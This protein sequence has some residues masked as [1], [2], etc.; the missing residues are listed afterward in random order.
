MQGLSDIFRRFA[1]RECKNVSPLYYD[2]ALNISA[3]RDLLQLASHCQQR[4]PIPN[5][6]LASIHFL[7][8]KSTKE[9]LADFYPSIRKNNA[10]AIPIKLVKDFCLK[11]R[12]EIIG[13]LETRMVQTNAINRT[14]YIMPI[15]S[16]EFRNKGALTVIDIGAS[17]GLNLNFEHYEYHLDNRK[18]YG[19]SSVKIKSRFLEGQLPEFDEI[20]PV[21]RKIGIDQNPLDL[22]LEDNALW[23]KAL[24]WPDQLER[25]ERMKAAIELS[26]KF[27][28]ELIRAGGVDDFKT[29]IRSIP[30]SD[31]LVIYHTHVLYQFTKEERKAFREMLDEIGHQRNFKYLAV[32]GAVVFD[33]KIDDKGIIVEL[34]SF[35]EGKKNSKIVATT[36]GHAKWIKWKR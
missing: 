10:T 33:K 5:L 4:Q 28:V 26:Q 35:S 25:F 6:F 1:E 19:N 31:P 9:D 7:L 34:T 8:L 32:E 29:I 14:A 13:L 3:E 27:P 17:S 36:N 18:I 2:L 24:I 12:K 11:H 20:I 22:R 23:L 21:K 30:P 15:L 16:S